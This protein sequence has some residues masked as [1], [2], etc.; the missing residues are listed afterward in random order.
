MSEQSLLTPTSV[1]LSL[2]PPRCPPHGTV[3]RDLFSG[4]AG[5]NRLYELLRYHDPS[6]ALFRQQNNHG[7]NNDY[8]S[9]TLLSRLSQIVK[10]IPKRP[11]PHLPSAPDLPDRMTRFIG[12]ILSLESQHSFRDS[13]KFRSVSDGLVTLSAPIVGLSNWRAARNFVQLSLAPE[14]SKYS[15]GGNGHRAEVGE[16]DDGSP[17]D[18]NAN[19]RNSRGNGWKRKKIVYGPH[20]MQF[21][22]L[23]LPSYEAEHVV[24]LASSKSSSNKDNENDSY[25]DNNEKDNNNDNDNN[26]N[27]NKTSVRGTIFFVHGGAW[28]AGCP[29]MY[30]L[31]AP[32]F[33]S[34]G[35]AVAIVGYRTYPDAKCMIRDQVGDIKDAWEELR[36]EL[37]GLVTPVARGDKKRGWVGNVVM[38]HSSGAHISLVMIVDMMGEMM[39]SHSYKSYEKNGTDAEV[40]RGNKEDYDSTTNN[41]EVSYPW[42]PDYYIGLS[43]PYD[44]SH[45]YDY[46]AGRGVEQI[47]PMKPICGFTRE[48]FDKASPAKRLLAYL[49]QYPE[50]DTDDGDTNALQHL[51]PK[52]LLIHGIEDGTVPFTATSDAARQLRSC[53]LENCYDVY[54]DK[55]GHQE[56]IMHFM[57]G[58]MAQEIVWEFLL[59]TCEFRRTSRIQHSRL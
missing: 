22:D 58:G 8:Q 42:N 45:H 10:S 16:S 19:T 48:N 14:P 9:H 37:N 1:A 49:S 11:H 56:V 12:A 27:K 18:L 13:G 2:S 43:G 4:S 24:G 46:E 51:A 28:G 17:S 59:E 57:L 39:S 44:I 50:R 20:P 21:I 36:N 25:I 7:N 55:T 52:M 15:I 29:W 30:R 26:N 40:W 53:G 34:R 35:F 54:L 33:L 5:A 23:F 3:I 31:V 47:S 38:G 41:S 32:T 6:D